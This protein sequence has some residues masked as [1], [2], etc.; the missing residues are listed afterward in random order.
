MLSQSGD[1]PIHYAC[2]EG[3][4]NIIRYL[5]TQNVNTTIK[6]NEDKTPADC[7]AHDNVNRVDILKLF[8]N[9]VNTLMYMLHLNK[10][11]TFFF[12]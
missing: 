1:T 8:T 6:N 3:H 12:N 4:V 11:F 5:L 7:V 10:V 9:Q 2:K